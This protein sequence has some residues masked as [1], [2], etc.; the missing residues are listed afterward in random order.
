V[1]PDVAV[2]A[3]QALLTAHLLALKKALT[4]F[5]DKRDV[6]DNLKTVIA[7]KEKELEALKA[8]SR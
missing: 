2:P 8:K 4:K 1:K 5:A 3:N 6:A 7:G